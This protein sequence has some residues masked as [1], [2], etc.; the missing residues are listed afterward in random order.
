LFSNTLTVA[1]L[2]ASLAVG[3]MAPAKAT[4]LAFEFG[5]A[6]AGSGIKASPRAKSDGWDWDG[7]RGREQSR[8]S[9]GDIRRAL[10]GQGFRDIENLRLRGAIYQAQ[11]LDP[12]GQP[13]GLVIN[14]RNG[15]I[16]NV[17]RPR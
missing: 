9:A 8:L 14:A 11:A 10:L 5:T 1:A 16:L 12:G 4:S 6:S 3:A 7:G 2:A 13:V 15:A 17:Y